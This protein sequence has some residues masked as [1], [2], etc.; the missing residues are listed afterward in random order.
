MVLALRAVVLVNGCGVSARFGAAGTAR[1]EG[2]AAQIGPPY[3]PLSGFWYL[4]PSSF[5]NG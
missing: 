3:S 1:P 2:D 4:I 5:L